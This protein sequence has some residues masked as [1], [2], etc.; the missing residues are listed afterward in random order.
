MSNTFLKYQDF[1]DPNKQGKYQSITIFDVD[2][3]LVVSKSLIKVTDTQ[4]GEKFKLTPAEFNE[5]ERHEKHHLDFSDF[6]NLDIL[7]AG[8]IIDKIFKILK[9]T[10][11]KGRRVGIITA[12]DDKE[13]IYQF[14]L[15]HGVMVNRN[16]IFAINDPSIGFSG[17]IAERKKEAFI[18]L[19][20][21]GFRDFIFYDDDVE[22]LK[23]AD[24]LN[25]EIK[26]IR[27][28]TK[29]VKP[30]WKPGSSTWWFIFHKIIM[31]ENFFKKVLND[32]S[33]ESKCVSRKVSALI[34]KDQ[35][36]ISTGYNGTLSGCKN[37]NEIFDE[38]NFDSNV[39]HIW[40]IKNEIHAEQNALAMAA[41]NGISVDGAICY[42]SLQPCNT[43]LLSLVQ[44]GI[45]EIVYIEPYE[46]SC[47][48]SDMIE[49][50]KNK[51]IIIRQF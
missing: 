15:H 43:C 10:M 22:N 32:L 49:Y 3:S 21:M 37:C 46:K 36:I 24:N 23:I 9:E 31:N 25:R 6:K 39:H 17:N 29:R 8:K 14:L 11:K 51:N 18:E 12:R 35:R 50:L 41:K 20:R 1:I 7:K 26:G 44:S 30:T 16:Y 40:S 42:S 33:Q 13:L 48:S 47:Y 28:K 34:V 45:I 2:D 27:I 4:T 5:F 19:I 38:S